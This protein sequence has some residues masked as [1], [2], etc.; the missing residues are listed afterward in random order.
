MVD[1]QGTQTGIKQGAVQ[2]ATLAAASSATTATDGKITT[3]ERVPLT[4][5]RIGTAML[6]CILILL[7]YVALTVAFA[8]FVG[9]S[10]A[11]CFYLMYFR[12][13]VGIPLAI[14]AA[15]VLVSLLSAAY[16]GDF[17]INVWG[18]S[19]EGPSAPITMWLACFL[20]IA[21]ALHQLLPEVKSTDDLPPTMAR[22]CKAS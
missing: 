15:L 12:G 17:K 10:A 16:G 2:N 22:F 1:V 14:I 7:L 3:L 4:L 8:L 20:V 9:P 11:I 6:V 21:L 18:M 13:V 5:S 19:F